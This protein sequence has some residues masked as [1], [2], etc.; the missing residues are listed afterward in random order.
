MPRSPSCPVTHIKSCQPFISSFSNWLF[1]G[2]SLAE[3]NVTVSCR[4]PLSCWESYCLATS[5]QLRQNRTEL[6]P[7]WS[8]L[9]S[10]ASRHRWGCQENL[11]CWYGHVQTMTHSRRLSSADQLS[12]GWQFCHQGCYDLACANTANIYVTYMI[13]GHTKNSRSLLLEYS[14]HVSN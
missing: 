8:K 4:D 7:L 5:F 10:I 2:I 3:K 1:R 13:K 11:K 14:L 12:L 6:F 9:E